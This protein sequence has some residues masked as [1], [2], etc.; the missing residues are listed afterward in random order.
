MQWED[1]SAKLTSRV[2]VS[3]YTTWFVLT[4][5]YA[6]I[7]LPWPTVFSAFFSRA[8][9]RSRNK[10]AA[11]ELGCRVLP[12]MIFP[13]VNGYRTSFEVSSAVAS[14][15]FSVSCLI[16][17]DMLGCLLDELADWW[18]LKRDGRTGPDGN[19]GFK[20]RKGLSGCLF[21]QRVGEKEN[22]REKPFVVAAISASLA[23][24][25]DAKP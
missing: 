12:W 8:D 3:E 16:A 23:V 13:P 2:L 17:D 9:S 10:S 25:L 5:L 18:R 6:K 24:F 19:S 14:T 1:G 22:E 21:L 11:L 4:L 20:P 15:T 7:C